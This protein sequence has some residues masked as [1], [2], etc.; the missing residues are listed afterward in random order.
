MAQVNSSGTE[1]EL[2]IQAVDVQGKPV[3]VSKDNTAAMTVVCFLGTEC[4]LVK[5]YAERLSAMAVEY[6]G[7]DVQFIGINSNRQDSLDDIQRFLSDHKLSFPLVQDSGNRIADLFGAVRTPEVFVLDR[8]L[9]VVYSGRIDDQ[10]SP[11]IQRTAIG[12][13]DLKEAIE[14]LLQGKQVTVPKTQAEGCLI[15]K[16]R[17]RI[18]TPDPAKAITYSSHVA[19]VLERHC[20]ECH[21]TGEIGPFSLESWDDVEGWAAMMVEVVDHGRMPPWHADD[22]HT[23]LANSRVMPESDKE[24]LRQW[25]AAG[26]PRGDESFKPVIPELTSG[27]QL[28]REPDMVVAMR[29]K[30]WEVPAE[31]TVE[32]QYF[33]T[34]PGFTTD[35]WVTAAQ[36]IPGNRSVVHH[37]IAFIRPPDG[38]EFRGV[39]WLT[40]YVPGQRLI[41]LPAGHARKVPAGS[42]IVF[43]MHYTTNGSPQEDLTKIG[44]LFGKPEDVTDEVITLIGIDQDFEVPP[45]AARHEVSGKVRWKPKQGKLLSFAPHMHVRGKS[46]QLDVERNGELSTI[47]NVPNYDFNWQHSYV[48]GQPQELAH[49]DEIHFKATFDNSAENPSN[50]DPT[51]WVNLGDQTWEE[52]AVVFLEVSE[53]LQRQSIPSEQQIEASTAEIDRKI[54]DYVNQFFEQLDT[55]GDQVLLRAEAPIAVRTQFWRYDHNGDGHADRAEITTIAERRFRR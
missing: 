54:A 27:W 38:S 4:P 2:S 12:R 39:G 15:G 8:G 7:R 50:P 5:L 19:G 22:S 37:A 3:I 14:E 34:D 41:P 10:F 30:P 11:G 21:R 44:L 28:D 55:N 24:I 1:A 53:P 52:M 35:Q 17:K 23:K 46:F 45:H 16:V 40:A 47:L 13:A 33:V 42:K 9:S 43:Q 31:G 51:Q 25:L 18:S 26:S 20:V 48:L 32:Y 36:I 6:R 49:I 29:D